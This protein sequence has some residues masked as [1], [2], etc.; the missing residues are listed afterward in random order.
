MYLLIS[1]IH[2]TSCIHLF[3]LDNLTGCWKKLD[4]E[5]LKDSCFLPKSNRMII[6][7]VAF[8]KENRNIHKVFVG[9]SRLRRR[10]GRRRCK[11]EDN[12]KLD[13]K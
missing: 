3:L 5:E 11:W 2:A 12:I 4:N 13:V 6:G 7:Q 1:H 9:K 10:I 8:V